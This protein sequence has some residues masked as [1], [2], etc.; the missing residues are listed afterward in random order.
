MMQGNTAFA[1]LVASYM[2]GGAAGLTSGGI[3]DRQVET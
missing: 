2:K 3:Q 1:Q